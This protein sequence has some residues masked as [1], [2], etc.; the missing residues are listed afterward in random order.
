MKKK[1]L[2]EFIDIDFFQDESDKIKS[3]IN[4]LE[5]NVILASLIVLLIIVVFMGWKSGLL[6]SISIPTSFLCSMIILSFFNVTINV[7]VLFS[8][9]LS[10][11]ILIDGAIIVVEYANRRSNEGFTKDKVFKLSAQKMF[12]PVLAST[13]TTLAA[14]FPLIFWPGIA[15][16][17]MF[18]LPV[19]LLAVLSSSLLVAL[20]FIPTLGSIFGTDK[21]LSNESKKNLNLLES[22]DLGS[23]GGMQG[24]YIILMKYC[25]ANPKKLI[26]LTLV[27]LVFIQLVYSKL[28]K[29]FEFFLQL[30]QIMQKLLFMLEETYLQLKRIK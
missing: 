16:E 15:G 4:D 26:L 28:G 14:F 3:Q 22:G 7:V 21:S 23:I 25:L 6:V 8:L 2:P 18:F 10:V 19:T 5:N 27:F 30:S 1:F 13:L 17:F 29:G 11:G 9:I 20:V 12:L 24:K